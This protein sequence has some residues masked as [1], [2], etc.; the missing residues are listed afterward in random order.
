MENT[1]DVPRRF[2]KKSF[3]ISDI[4]VESTKVKTNKGES[5][6]GEHNIVDNSYEKPSYDS[7]FPWTNWNANNEAEYAVS[8]SESKYIIDDIKFLNN[9]FVHVKSSTKL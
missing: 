1:S 8:H 6:I 3:L 5:Q 2:P 4:L 7:V 9:K